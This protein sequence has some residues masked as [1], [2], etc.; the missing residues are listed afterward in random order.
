MTTPQTPAGWYSDPDGS[1]GQRYW[2]G[3]TW[4]HHRADAPQPPPPPPGPPP[5]DATGAHRQL[6]VRY[7]AVCAA[8]LAVLVAVAVYAAFFADDGSVTIEASDDPVTSQTAGP[9]ATGDSGWGD[10]PSETSTETTT[11]APPTDA[12]EVTDGPLAFT[13]HG[14]EVGPTVES[15]DFPLEKTAAGEFVIVYLTVTNVSD[16]PATFLGTFQKLRAGSTV[17]SI[18]DEATFYTGG[19][20][21]ELGPG[22][23]AEVAVAYDVPPGTS[24]DAIELRAD[25]LSPGTE[26]PLS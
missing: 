25:P 5:P 23:Q 9:P 14:V 24:P 2:D 11:E 16:A 22:D 3:N 6:L 4:T 8:L 12:G 18:D 21:A 20:L 26:V 1:S 13:V 19:A 15:A 10:E 7:L 17:Y